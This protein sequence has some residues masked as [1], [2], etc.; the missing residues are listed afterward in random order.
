MLGPRSHHTPETHRRDRRRITIGIAIIIVVAIVLGEVIN[1]IVKSSPPTAKRTEATWVAAVAGIIS[2][3]NTLSP[4][5]H[6]IRAHA[7]DKASYDRVTIELALRDL[8]R[9]SSEQATSF[10]TLGFQAPTATMG[11]LVTDALTWRAD[12]LS[13]LAHGVTL[14]VSSKVGAAGAI[15]AL[16]AAGARLVAA[17]AAY[18]RAVKL[19]GDKHVDGTLP[20]SSWITNPRQWSSSAVGAWA[21]GLSAAPN[22][23]AT[24]A[25]AIVAMTLEPPPLRITGLPAPTVPST[26]ASTTT[27]ST[28]TSTTA[29]SSTTLPASTSTTTSTIPGP[30]TTSQIPP[31]GSVSIIAATSH[32][33]VIVV[34]QNDGNVAIRGARVVALL[35]PLSRSNRGNSSVEH[36]VPPLAP[37]ASAY[38]V[39]TKLAVARTTTYKLLV[40]AT[41]PSGRAVRRSVKL[42]VGG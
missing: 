42:E 2:E 27:S 26:A 22:L 38:I 33:R 5:I 34:V 39:F 10:E 20:D 29:G 14:A 28:T 11:T 30:T 8:A 37:D 35:V 23:L 9:A 40:T 6:A 3:S 16:T 41:L 32:V 12:G 18:K 19:V 21:R 4:T 15:A 25:I 7:T 17:D 24:P 31:L 13:E 1:D 36:N